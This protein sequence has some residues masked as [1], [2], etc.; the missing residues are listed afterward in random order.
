MT[1]FVGPISYLLRLIISHEL[2]RGAH[3]NPSK[4]DSANL[5]IADFLT[6]PE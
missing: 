5:A 6:T 2:N 3:K 1:A 4:Q